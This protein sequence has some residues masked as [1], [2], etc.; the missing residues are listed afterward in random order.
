MDIKLSETL[1]KMAANAQGATGSEADVAWYENDGNEET[2]AGAIPNS[3]AWWPSGKGDKDR[4]VTF[5]SPAS[6]R[7]VGF[8]PIKGRC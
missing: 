5:S 7:M 8:L 2:G 6:R 1:K 3:G 4:V